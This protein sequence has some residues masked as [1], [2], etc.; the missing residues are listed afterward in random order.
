MRISRWTV[1]LLLLCGSLFFLSGDDLSASG[2]YI[3]GGPRP[4]R[5]IKPELYH[6]GKSV[7]AGKMEAKDMPSLRDEQNELLRQYQE[8]LPRTVQKKIDLASYA[9]KLDEE[10]MTALMYFLEIRY[11]IKIEGGKVE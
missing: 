3:G 5:Q 11:K 4:P 1:Y 2:S 10:Q 7:Y 9:G 6:L 8:K